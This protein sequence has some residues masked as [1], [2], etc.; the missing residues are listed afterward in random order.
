M[1][2]NFLQII[3]FKQRTFIKEENRYKYKKKNNNIDLYIKT[4]KSILQ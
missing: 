3:A 1:K 2:N 4:E